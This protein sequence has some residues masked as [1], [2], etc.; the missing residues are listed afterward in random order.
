MFSTRIPEQVHCGDSFKSNSAEQADLLNS[1]F[2]KQFF[3]RSKYEIRID[4]N[5]S[6]YYV[7]L[8]DSTY[9]INLVLLKI[10]IIVQVMGQ[11]SAQNSNYSI[12]GHTFFGP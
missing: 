11:E 5:N 6:H 2:Y 12:F 10:L 7:I 9:R 3:E 8:F 4:H 1:F